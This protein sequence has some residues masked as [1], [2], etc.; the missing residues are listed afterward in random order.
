MELPHRP[1]RLRRD[2]VRD[3]VSETTLTP[4]DLV[5]PVFVDATADERTPIPSMPGQ[6][7]VPLADAVDRTREI[8]DTGVEAIVLFGIPASKDDTGSRAYADDGIVQEATRRITSETDAYVITDVCL[9]EY[10]SH[11]HC[12]VVEADA[13][14]DPTLTV[15]NDETLSLLAETAVS[16]AEAG[17]EM[18][19]PS[20]MTDGMVDAI[21]TA[22]DDAG[23][24]D[25]PIMSYAAKYESAFYG[26]FRDAADGAPSFGDRRHYQ[27][28]PANRREASREVALDVEQGADVLM[29]KPA[30][31]YLDVV[32][33]VRREFDRPVAAYN[34]SGEYAMLHAA[35]EKGWLDL[36]SVAHESL[37]SIKRAGADLI[38]TYFAEDVAE[39]L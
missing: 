10:T 28:D 16:H 34:V 38:I 8:L 23:F 4:A 24:S 27:M 17:A 2:G 31:P 12:G 25:V 26:P 7:R 3:L 6:E 37:L 35:A 22:L 32:S 29:V 30:L 11:G 14:T 15:K 13:D 39:T 18:I 33:D 5:A 21:R 1:R 36:E 20:A 19:A 9:C